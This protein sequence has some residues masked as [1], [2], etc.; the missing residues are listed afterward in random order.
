MA[1]TTPGEVNHP[2]DKVYSNTMSA[3]MMESF[4]A[5]TQPNDLKAFKKYIE[6]DK[7]TIKNYSSSIQYTYGGKMNIFSTD[8]ANGV[9]QVFPSPVISMMESMVGNVDLG[10]MQIDTSMMS[11]MTKMMN[12]WQELIDNKNLLNEQ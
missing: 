5:E 2:L 6:S 8:T 9:N 7:S 4:S 3:A 12:S 1:G 11:S 10:G